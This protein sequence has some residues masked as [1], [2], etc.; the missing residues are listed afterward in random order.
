MLNTNPK[1]SLQPLKSASVT[2]NIK[3][4]DPIKN[5]YSPNIP[6]SNLMF[7]TGPT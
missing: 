3:S 4:K 2:V 1:A 5:I 7:F 6:G